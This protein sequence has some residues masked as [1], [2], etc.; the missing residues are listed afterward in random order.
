MPTITRSPKVQTRR[1]VE[2][3]WMAKQR[4]EALDKMQSYDYVR[5]ENERI[6][7]LASMMHNIK[8]HIYTKYDV[9]L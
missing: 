9:I 8:F 2:E 4:L 6:N 5:M 7:N 1:Q 3:I